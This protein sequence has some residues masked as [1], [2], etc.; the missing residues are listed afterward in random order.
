MLEG[1]LLKMFARTVFLALQSV[2]WNCLTSVKWW[3][4]PCQGGPTL[5]LQS[6]I[7]TQYREL[8][9]SGADEVSKSCCEGVD[10]F[11]HSLIVIVKG[12]TAL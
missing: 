8:M 1:K 9:L 7:Q 12:Q 3:R 6:L 2:L 10:G 11:L 5:T 4:P